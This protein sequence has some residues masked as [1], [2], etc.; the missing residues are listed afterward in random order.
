MAGVATIALGLTKDPW[1]KEE[2]GLLPSSIAADIAAA[3]EA[4]ILVR[5]KH[6]I[7]TQLS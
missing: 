2:V 4:V 6:F 1:A 3:V 7:S 5:A